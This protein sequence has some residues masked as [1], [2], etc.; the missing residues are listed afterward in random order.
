MLYLILTIGLLFGIVSN[1]GIAEK[2]FAAESF[3]QIK[4][5]VGKNTFL[6]DDGSMWS[7]IDG[8]RKIHTP[9]NMAAVIGNEHG[10]LGINSD[11]KLI[12]WDIGNAPHIVEGQTGVKQVTNYYW[13]KTDGTVWTSTGKEKKNLTNIALIACEDKTF[14]ALSKN[15]D[16]LFE[17]PY[18]P[19]VFKKLGAITDASSVTSITVYDNSRV[20]LL[21]DSGKVVVYETFNF[22]D[23][24]V[25]IPVTV[26]DDAVHI[27]YTEG[28]PTPALVVTRKD[29]TVWT[30]GNYKDRWKL[31]NQVSGLS[32]IV[33]TAVAT[34]TEHFYAM[35]SDGSWVLFS[36]GDTK[37][38]DAPR[39][40]DLAVSISN[41]KSFVG[42]S[43]KVDIQETYTNGAKIKVPI[44]QANITMD[45]PYLLS[46]QPSG[47]LKVLAVGQT[48]VTVTSSGLSKTLKVS[49]SHRTNL[50]YAKQVNGVIFVPAKSVIEA[51]GG[52]VSV[53][54]G[55]FN[56]KFGETTMNFRAGDLNATLNG[57]AIQLKAAPI[58]DKNGMLIPSA[59]LTDALGASTQW[60]TKWKQAVISIGDARMT[61][62]ST[63]TAALIKKAVQGSLIQY[64]GKTYW[65]NYFE[66]W[67]RFSK[68]TVTDIMPNDA[69]EFIVI[70]KTSSGQTRKSYSMSSSSVMQI[71]SGDSDFLNYDPYKKYNWSS[72]IWNQIKAGKVS[73]GMT[74][75]QVQFS[76]GGPAAKSITQTNGVKIE[77][78]V[79]SNF[80]TVA[81]V[82]GKVNFIIY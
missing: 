38:V 39:I 9:G 61:I 67:D 41:Q 44:N 1:N 33:K 82:N 70:F 2:A 75:E 47:N 8:S 81:F 17:D 74:K 30:T 16:V 23:H 56:V 40:K 11:G 36:E 13:L 25:I 53:S 35:H 63:D 29:G 7:L 31:A 3:P 69:G 18:K 62:V 48:Q 12:Q 66:Q 43:L 78:W 60:E 37:Q 28:N 32:Q 5:M 10:G 50:K 52:I 34:D 22:D 19:G 42:D 6:M 72:S 71:F 64:I 45:K 76:W 26:A 27:T 79:Y 14:A 77:T 68:V 59:L 57:N 55:G 54:D 4:D 80:D 15:G 21:Y 46:L 51:L 24:G 20:A 49:G 65:V 58:A 73:L